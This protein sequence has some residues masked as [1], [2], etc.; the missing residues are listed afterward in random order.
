MYRS[1]NISI[2]IFY[3]G[4]FIAGCSDRTEEKT[5]TTLQREENNLSVLNSSGV[6]TSKYDELNDLSDKQEKD[7]SF[8]E[9]KIDLVGLNNTI[10]REF[11]ES[12]ELKE[13][14]EY[15]NGL[16]HGK[17]KRWYKD[18]QLFKEGEMVEDK[19][20]GK[21]REW[22]PDGSPKLIGHYMEGKQNGEWLFFDKNGDVLPSISYE[23]G[24]EVTR[25]LP[26]VFAD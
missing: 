22:Y 17:R 15:K 23:N 12:G 4:F 7:K 5:D 13:E 8:R 16:K 2:L 9:E 20:D 24:R 18:G 21:Y 6:I 14:I 19:W 1:F 10:L 11:F 26:K 3:F 25:D